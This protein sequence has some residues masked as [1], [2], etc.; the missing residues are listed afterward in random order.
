MAQ[1]SGWVKLFGCYSKIGARFHRIDTTAKDPLEVLPPGSERSEDA[2]GNRQNA[3]VGG[4]K[5]LWLR[6]L[7]SVEKD[8]VFE[9]IVLY[10]SSMCATRPA[11][12]YFFVLFVVAA[13]GDP[14]CNGT[15]ICGVYEPHC[16]WEPELGCNG[17]VSDSSIDCADQVPNVQ[18]RRQGPMQFV[19]SWGLPS[20]VADES[21]TIKYN[22][23][24]YDTSDRFD[25]VPP[26]ST[27]QKRSPLGRYDERF[28]R[29]VAPCRVWFSDVDHT[30]LYESGQV[31]SFT[32]IDSGFGV[33]PGGLSISSVNG[34]GFSATYSVCPLPTT[35][36]SVDSSTTGLSAGLCN[37]TV[38]NAGEYYLEDGLVDFDSAA[39]AAAT[40]PPQIA[41]HLT[42]ELSSS[43]CTSL[44]CR[45]AFIFTND[46]AAGFQTS[47]GQAFP[48]IKKGHEYAFAVIRQ[49]ND[50]FGRFPQFDAD[51]LGTNSTGEW[52]KIRALDL[53]SA[54][55]GLST[56]SCS[57]NKLKVTWM[58]PH[59]LGALS[60]EERIASGLL[61]VSPLAAIGGLAGIVKFHAQISTTSDFATS[62]NHTVS[63][64]DARSGN[65]YEVEL[66]NVLGDGVTVYIRVGV[67]TE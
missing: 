50:G 16:C 20:T 42:K 17:T 22:L 32:L 11:L 48:G 61:P 63:E 26:Y 46:S 67:E 54:P 29:N 56:S 2:G 47:S 44:L 35:R 4:Y 37:F 38:T 43:A 13:G 57:P 28:N 18:L 21:R 36:R 24:V 31:T 33:A 65:G 60:R 58:L 52:V 39:T 3:R 30:A 55:Q 41:F 8:V 34:S 15:Q 64:F 19:V 5:T 62:I 45:P 12:C 66:T 10:R 6:A 59:D 27:L 40:S 53:S 14:V 23:L 1:N 25:N 49:R 7:N 9:Q 51:L